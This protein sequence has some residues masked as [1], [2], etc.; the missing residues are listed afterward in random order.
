MNFGGVG[1]K[2]SLVELI[3]PVENHLVRLTDK[4]VNLKGFVTKVF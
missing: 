3:L 4:L 1:V 2:Q